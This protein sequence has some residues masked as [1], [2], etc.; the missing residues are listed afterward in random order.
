MTIPGGAMVRPRKLIC[1]QGHAVSGD[2]VLIRRNG[3]G[4]TFRTCKQCH[5]AYYRAR[6]LRRHKNP[7]LPEPKVREIIRCVFE[8][9]YTVEKLHGRVKNKWIGTG[10]VPRARLLTWCAANPRLGKRLLAKAAENAKAVRA[11]YRQESRITVA[12]PALAHNMGVLDTI[13][14]VLPRWLE[15]EDRRDIVADMWLAVADGRLLPRDVPTRAR[16]F[17]RAHGK[18]YTN[19]GRYAFNSLDAP[20]GQESGSATRIEFLTENDRLWG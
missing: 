13:E 12:A 16:E 1:K 9:G 11:I 3:D 20:V 17:V 6:E 8:D 19:T 18:K 7:T 14:A 2:N 15:P 5:Q 4:N 10:V